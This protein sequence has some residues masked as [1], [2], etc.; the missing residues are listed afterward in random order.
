LLRLFAGDR[1]TCQLLAKSVKGQQPVHYCDGPNLPI[2]SHFVVASRLALHS[3]IL[4]QKLGAAHQWL[5]RA[6]VRARVQNCLPRVHFGVFRFTMQ[7]ADLHA[8]SLALL[9]A[10]FS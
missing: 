9:L 4:R 10:P 2:S 8:F 6:R 3:D 5:R 7:G 1:S